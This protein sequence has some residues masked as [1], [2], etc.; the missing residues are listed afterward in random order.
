MFNVPSH[1]TNE[2][3]CI[4]VKHQDYPWAPIGFTSE[5]GFINPHSDVIYIYAILI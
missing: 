5:S 4:L 2:T 1:V 3:R